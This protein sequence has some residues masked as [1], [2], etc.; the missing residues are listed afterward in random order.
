MDENSPRYV[1]ST[2]L[3]GYETFIERFLRDAQV[4]F[5][6]QGDVICRQDEPMDR[7]YLILRGTI[8]V[9]YTNGEGQT[10]IAAVIDRG[11]LT[12]VAGLNRYWSHHTH[13]CRTDAMVAI[14]PKEAVYQW[15]SEMLLALIQMQTRKIE[16]A[17]Q[18][19]KEHST[20][21]VRDRLVRLLLERGQMEVLPLA[22]E[23][24]VRFT[25]TKQDLA[26][27]IGSTRERVG[28]VL[29]ELRAEGLIQMEGK[30]LCFYPSRLKK[31][32]SQG[33]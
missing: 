7:L 27:F 4:V 11:A 18:Q 25:F 15:D 21:S 13:T 33:R 14:Q 23:L 10:K 16:L 31:G 17:F 1:I 29:Q 20:A 3:D 19:I 28:Q 22:V 32:H 8:E 24:P 6:N 9:S 26:N 12:G 30:E 2:W 5:Y